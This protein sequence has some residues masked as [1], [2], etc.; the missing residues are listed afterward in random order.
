MGQ[1]SSIL[2]V[3]FASAL[4]LVSACILPV[5][6]QQSPPDSQPLQDNTTIS[7]GSL[8][9]EGKNYFAAN[10]I[11]AALNS[12]RQFAQSS[13]NNIAVHFWIGFML[14]QSGDSKGALAAYSK[15][16]DLAKSVGMDSAELRINLGNS[17]AKLGYTKE[18]RF[19]YERAIIIDS[20]NPLAYLGLSK[21]LIDAGEFDSALQ[22]LARY[23][24]LNGRDTSVPLL[25]GLALAGQG[26]LSA[27][28]QQLRS[29]LTLTGAMNSSGQ[30]T[31]NGSSSGNTL[32]QLAFKVLNEIELM[33]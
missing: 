32:Q 30:P 17:L 22:A 29:Y 21:C 15:S 28:Q 33:H 1:M 19:D 6:A 7:T 13:P 10:N 8:L 4:S 27:A 26:S 25:R 14:D 18:P 2:P 16:L 23:E 11:P 9:T 12:F 5:H 24:S 20:L 31:Q 3:L